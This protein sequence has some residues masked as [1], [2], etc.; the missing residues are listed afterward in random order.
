MAIVSSFNFSRLNIRRISL[1]ASSCLSDM[2]KES[3]PCLVSGQQ[4]DYGD[5]ES[6]AVS[7]SSPTKDVTLYLGG[8][9]G[10]RL[11]TFYGFR[12]DDGEKVV[13]KKNERE[14]YI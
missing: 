10:G 12:K 2:V 4:G 1:A 13:E 8:G 7:L 14:M 6:V 5:R 9:T 3:V 11:Y